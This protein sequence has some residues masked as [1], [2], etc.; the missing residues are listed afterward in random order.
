[1]QSTVI[2]SNEL[3]YQSQVHFSEVL[4]IIL[5]TDAMFSRAYGKINHVFN[6]IDHPDFTDLND[7]SLH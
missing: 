3:T 2:Q 1:M 7:S 6:R 4:L 5:S